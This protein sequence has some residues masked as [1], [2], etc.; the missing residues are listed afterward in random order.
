[1]LKPS[2]IYVTQSRLFGSAV[3]AANTLESVADS[4]TRD[5]YVASGSGLAVDSNGD[6]IDIAAG[7]YAKTAGIVLTFTGS[8][9]ITISFAALAA[10][11]GVQ[12]AG[13]ASFAQWSALLFQNV[14]GQPLSLAPGGSCH[15][16]ERVR[17]TRWPPAMR[18][19]SN[20]RRVRR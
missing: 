12:V 6:G 2:F 13:A 10:A 8:T 14:G 20:P 15:S 5:A 1:M 11:T 18:H 7:G 9:P 17:S 16:A 3:I 4:S 19:I